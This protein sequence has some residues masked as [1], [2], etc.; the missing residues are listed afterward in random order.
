VH[1]SP[2]GMDFE[3]DI[4]LQTNMA[5]FT[6]KREVPPLGRRTPTLATRTRVWKTKYVMKPT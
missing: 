1:S 3:I 6:F 4:M 2:F 5:T